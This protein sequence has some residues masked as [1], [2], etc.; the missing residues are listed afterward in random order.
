MRGS[1][2]TRLIILPAVSTP[3]RL[4]FLAAPLEA[5]RSTPRW[6]TN[7]PI[8][9]DLPC[10]SV[11]QIAGEKLERRT[12][13]ESSRSYFLQGMRHVRFA[14]TAMPALLAVLRSFSPALKQCRQH[15]AG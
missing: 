4:D 6:T 13:T 8:S 9:N 3:A 5:S 10:V 1:G 7:K 2:D 11:H 12:Q 14:P 15:R